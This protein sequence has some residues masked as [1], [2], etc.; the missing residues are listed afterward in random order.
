MLVRDLVGDSAPFYRSGVN[1]SAA[2]VGRI[3]T[4]KLPAPEGKAPR[5][6]LMYTHCTIE[7]PKTV[8]VGQ[9]YKLLNLPDVVSGK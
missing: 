3:H 7:A 8:A 5:S 1:K 4:D 2:T 6:G 9:K